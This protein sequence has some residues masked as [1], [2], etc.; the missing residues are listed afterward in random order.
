MPSTFS[1]LDTSER[2][3]RR[4]LDVIDLFSL[5]DTRDQ[6]GIA[7]IR[8]AWADMLVPGTS[9]IQTRARY[10]FFIPWIYLDLERR[11]V[12]LEKVARYARR[13]ELALIEAIHESDPESVP[14][15]SRAGRALRRLPSDIYW[16]GLGT[17]R[18][19]LFD[20]G[21]DRYH[22][23]F[24]RETPWE[25]GE[26][27]A[28]ARGNW[29]PHL[30]VPPDDFPG[31]ATLDLTRAESEYLR[32]K[33]LQHA[34]GSLHAFLV[35]LEE[36]WDDVPFAWA[37]P[38]L[39]HAPLRLRDLVE[40]A[41]LFSS[42]MHGAALL[43][44]LMLAQ[45]REWSERIDHYEMVLDEWA[46]EIDKDRNT[47]RAWNR[48]AF[49][50]TTLEQNLRIPHPSRGFA[51]SWIDRVLD[52]RHPRE[53]TTDEPTREFIVK[54]ELRLKGNRARLTHR[55]HLERWSGS[56]GANALDYRWPITQRIV[57]DVQEGL[58]RG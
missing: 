13:A 18:V 46:A 5:R 49:W 15:G 25:I 11:R 29:D 6:L 38:A 51:D 58:R 20:C 8:D 12:R 31:R 22:R 32:D 47:L 55:E 53:L 26:D 24:G 7:G 23:T 57:R 56:S 3:R 30:P 33:I 2:D 54:R 44:N 40:H 4:A 27:E 43:Y 41:R 34:P 10:F 45:R 19:R 28:P 14:I 16:G 36:L 37:H 1:W 50:A 48:S 17:L 21:R 39:P 35:G 52:A 9:T 42:V